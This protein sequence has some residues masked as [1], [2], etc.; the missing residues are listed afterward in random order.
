M[1]N[2]CWKLNS[3]ARAYKKRQ[4]EGRERSQDQ[5]EI[6]T[7]ELSLLIL[8]HKSVLSFAFFLFSMRCLTLQTRGVCLWDYGFIDNRRSR[9]VDILLMRWHES[10]CDCKTSSCLL[11]VPWACRLSY[12]LLVV[13]LR[14]WVF[15][16]ILGFGEMPCDLGHPGVVGTAAE[17][18]RC[19]CAGGIG[20]ISGDP[21]SRP[22]HLPQKNIENK[23]KAPTSRPLGNSFLA[24]ALTC[25]FDLRS[26]ELC[27]LRSALSTSRRARNG[28]QVQ[29]LV[30]SARATLFGGGKACFSSN[31]WKLHTH[32]AR[33][34]QL[35]KSLHHRTCCLNLLL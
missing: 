12:S 5:E 29:G 32:T 6:R 24:T 20:K 16:C 14:L 15:F 19:L 9:D 17:W 26:A 28:K 25:G 10:K 22:Y 34:R 30:P 2:V 31:I 11:K 23:K 27:F 13:A 8:D 33:C 21:R 3:K 35:W 4:R 1:D 18:T 7:S